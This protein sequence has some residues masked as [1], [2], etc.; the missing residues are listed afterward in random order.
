MLAVNRHLLRALEGV[1]STPATSSQPDAM[2]ASATA[3]KH[4]WMQH[5][6][7]AMQYKALQRDRMMGN[8]GA[9]VRRVFFVDGTQGPKDFFE[10]TVRS[11]TEQNMYVV[12]FL[13]DVVDG[14][15]DEEMGE[16]DFDMYSIGLGKQGRS[17][18]QHTAALDHE[19]DNAADFRM[20]RSE[21]QK[22]LSN[23]PGQSA[24]SA[25]SMRK[26]VEHQS[27][28]YR[29]K[30]QLQRAVIDEIETHIDTIR[31]ALELHEPAG[32][33]SHSR[34]V[35][36]REQEHSDVTIVVLNVEFESAHGVLIYDTCY[37]HG[38]FSRAVSDLLEAVHLDCD[39]LSCAHE[40]D[41]R[42]WLNLLW[43]SCVWLLS[44]TNADASIRLIM[45]QHLEQLRRLVAE[46][47][48][49]A[50]AAHVLHTNGANAAASDM[51]LVEPVMAD[52]HNR[53]RQY[54]VG[55]HVPDKLAAIGDVR[56]LNWSDTPSAPAC[57]TC[58]EHHM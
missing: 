2:S 56:S 24:N 49:I 4:G 55:D 15:Y 28:E 58:S 29:S 1:P 35:L 31:Q 23:P 3:L 7:S 36:L 21:Q 6:Q 52:M 30:L 16:Q 22:T 14:G 33:A 53:A 19:Q 44:A 47:A 11:I 10:G 45:T 54:H 41:A 48:P 25:H 57:P 46:L 34:K 17:E 51:L 42:A 9:K 40:L 5:G 32:K 37:V 8:I 13:K 38:R 26:T 20:D 18:P 43:R 12:H 50:H 27:C 39:Q